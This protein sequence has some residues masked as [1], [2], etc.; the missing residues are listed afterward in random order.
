MAAARMLSQR[1][2][3]TQSQKE[4]VQHATQPCWK[5]LSACGTPTPPQPPHSAH[6]LGTRGA[7]TSNEIYPC[8]TEK[9]N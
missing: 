5:G 6:E 7:H 1:H 4:V 9:A 8:Q 2:V 3:L